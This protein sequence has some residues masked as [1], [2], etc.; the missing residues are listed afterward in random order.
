MGKT[1]PVGPVSRVWVLSLEPLN[2]V[3]SSKTLNSHD[4]QL[5]LK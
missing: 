5:L 4:F 3:A 2:E 1:S